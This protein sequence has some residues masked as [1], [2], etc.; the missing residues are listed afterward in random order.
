MNK[1]STKTSV[2]LKVDF[3]P[4]KT[5]S[6]KDKGDSLFNLVPA[7]NVTTSS[8]HIP[9]PPTKQEGLCYNFYRTNQTFEN[10]QCLSCCEIKESFKYTYFCKWCIE[11]CAHKGHNIIKSYT[12]SQCNCAYSGACSSDVKQILCG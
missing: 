6:S 11:H 3:N 5:G 12:R 8:P 1:S 10:Y 2:G 9:L 7:N 4:K